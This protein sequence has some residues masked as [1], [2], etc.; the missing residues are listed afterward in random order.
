MQTQLYPAEFL[1]DSLER[2]LARWPGRGRGVYNAVLLSLV[3]ALAVLPLLKVDVAVRSGGLVRPLTEKHEVRARAS[4]VVERLLV[5]ENQ[6]VEAGAP[7]LELRAGQLDEQSGLI[8]SQID[9]K[10]RLAHDLELLVRGGSGGFQ[11]SRPQQERAQ[12]Q[13]ELDQAALAR[14]QAEREVERTRALA[15]RNLVA[16]TELEQKEFAL[17]QARSQAVQVRQRWLSQWQGQL[18]EA[19]AELRQLLSRRGEVE[20]SRGLYVVAAPVA[21]TLEEMRGVSAGSFVTAG[22][23][24]AVISPSSALVAE[25]YVSPRDVGMVHTGTPV[26]F[27][28]DAFNYNDWGFVAGRVEEISDD[29]VLVNSQPMFKVRCSLERDQLALSNGVRGRLRKGMTLQARFVVAERTLLQL[30]FDRMEDWLDPARSPAP[31][32]SA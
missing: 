17:E 21:G 26:R 9:E 4:G 31:A 15:A 6:R 19:R 32:A 20:E 27:Q 29:F 10:S 18:T 7:L 28:V 2:H 30:L 11:A 1:E 12:M 24:L 23:A 16:A 5:R 25:V 13:A 8:A 22:E 14:A 3:G